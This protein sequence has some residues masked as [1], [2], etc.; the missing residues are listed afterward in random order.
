MVRFVIIVLVNVD[1]SDYCF[2]GHRDGF[3]TYGGNLV[4]RGVFLDVAGFSV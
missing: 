4:H 3:L 1:E 2:G